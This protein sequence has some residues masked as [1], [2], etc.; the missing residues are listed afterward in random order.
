MGQ[1]TQRISKDR[2][3]DVVGEQVWDNLIEGR[4]EGELKTGV[5]ILG[6]EIAFS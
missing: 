1:Q 3:K 5:R 6:Y 2:N 4:G